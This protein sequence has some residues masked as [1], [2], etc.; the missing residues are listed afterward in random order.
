LSGPQRIAHVAGQDVAEP[1]EVLNRNRLVQPIGRGNRL[2][3]LGADIG[4]N[5]DQDIDET[6]G[7][8]PHR[9]EHQ[10]RDPEQGRHEHRQQSPGQKSKHR[11]GLLSRTRPNEI[12][13]W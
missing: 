2:S 11:R 4:T 6:A 9:P 1:F 10:D 8:Q 3:L 5:P 12:V 13:S 7:Y